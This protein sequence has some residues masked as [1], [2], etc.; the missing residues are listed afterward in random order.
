M[1]RSRFRPGFT[2]VELLVVIAIIGIL[3]AL[4]L[5]AIQ[6]AREAARRSQCANNMKQLGI[7]MH[8]YAD[9]YKTFPA[10]GSL[11]DAPSAIWYSWAIPILPFMEQTPIYDGIMAQARPNGTGL[12]SPWDTGNNAWNNNYWRIDFPGFICP[13]DYVPPDRGESPALLNYKVCMGDDY[14][15]NHFPYPVAKQSRHFSNGSVDA[16]IFHH[17]WH[18]HDG[19]AG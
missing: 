18:L 9:T 6:A 7:A 3:V 19:H 1:Q 17:R 4:L 16:N 8:N 15:Q 2:L 5:P 13:S 14:H 11:L 10:L 12:P